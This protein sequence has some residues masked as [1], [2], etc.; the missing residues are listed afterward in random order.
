MAAAL[1]HGLHDSTMGMDERRSPLVQA[2]AKGSSDCHAA[3][4][5]GRDGY[6]A[7]FAERGW[8]QGALVEMIRAAPGACGRRPTMSCVAKRGSRWPPSTARFPSASS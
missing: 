3:Y 4:L 7:Y 6:A 5:A 8:L 1:R 2:P